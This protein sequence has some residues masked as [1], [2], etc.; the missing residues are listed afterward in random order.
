MRAAVAALGVLIAVVPG[1]GQSRISPHSRPR[2]TIDGARITVTYGRPS[3][4]GRA[5]FG[6][7]RQRQAD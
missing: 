7:L 6:A 3:M 1:A 4:R 2:P 5:L